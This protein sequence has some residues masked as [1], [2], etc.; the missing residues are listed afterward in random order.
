MFYVVG[1][2]FR[3]FFLPPLHDDG[4]VNAVEASV[5]NFPTNAEYMCVS[6]GFFKEDGTYELQ[7]YRTGDES[8]HGTFCNWDVG[9][10]RIE[11]QKLK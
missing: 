8:R 9:V 7:R 5:A 6:E 11:M 2:R 10:L 4:S 1:N 3:I